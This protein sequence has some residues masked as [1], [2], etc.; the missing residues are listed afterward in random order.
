MILPPM[1]GR[2][3]LLGVG[4]RAGRPARFDYLAAFASMS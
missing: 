2:L 1:L 4:R 3:S